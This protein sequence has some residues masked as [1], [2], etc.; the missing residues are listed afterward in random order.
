MR[1]GE[2]RSGTG[3]ARKPVKKEKVEGQARQAGSGAGDEGGSGGGGGGEERDNNRG[4]ENKEGAR[5]K[6]LLYAKNMQF[7]KTKERL[8]GLLE[9]AG[10]TEWDV[11]FAAEA[12]GGKQEELLKRGHLFAGAGGVPGARGA[13]LLMHTRWKSGLVAFRARNARRAAADIDIAGGKYTMVAVYF[14][15]A[16]YSDHNRGNYRVKQPEPIRQ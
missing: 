4:K 13:A 2:R 16:G 5:Q 9:E 3:T 10:E 11:I 15:H 1:E 6:L 14:P 12:W 8:Q 7:F